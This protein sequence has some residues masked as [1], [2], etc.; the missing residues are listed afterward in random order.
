LVINKNIEKLEKFLDARK[1]S[2][3]ISANWK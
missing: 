2:K 3:Q 1:Q